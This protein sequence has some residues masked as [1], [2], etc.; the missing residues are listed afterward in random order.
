[1][2]AASNDYAARLWSVSEQKARVGLLLYR[3]AACIHT[4][5]ISVI[6]ILTW[7]WCYMLYSGKVW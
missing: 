3:L 6:V 1:M 4:L 7:L 5:S 2:L